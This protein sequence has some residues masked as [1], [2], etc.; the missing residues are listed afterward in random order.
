VTDNP[1]EELITLEAK[2]VPVEGTRVANVV[3]A[4]EHVTLFVRHVLDTEF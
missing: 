3:N 4:E 2:G 1:F